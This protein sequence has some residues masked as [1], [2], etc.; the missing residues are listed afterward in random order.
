MNRYEMIMR[1]L[2]DE[3]NVNVAF[4]TGEMDRDTWSKNIQTID[5]RLSVLGVRL[6][7]VPII[8]SEIAQ[9]AF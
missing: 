4:A 8:R 3:E 7:Q 2:Q 1:L 5:E 9:P 6:A